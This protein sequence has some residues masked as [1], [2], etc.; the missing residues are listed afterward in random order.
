MSKHAIRSFSDGLRRELHKFN[1]KVI[2]IEPAMY[3]TPIADWNSIKNNIDVIWNQTP[4]EV[5]SAYNE[6]WRNVFEKRT[7]IAL[8]LTRKQT[9]EVIDAMI[10]AITLE[11]PQI[12]YRCGGFMDLNTLWNISYLPEYIQDFIVKYGTN[13]DALIRFLKLFSSKSKSVK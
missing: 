9:N 5:Q 1:I 6:K 2:T 11:K 12:Y 13:D 8:K 7:E 10:E 4:I 3:R